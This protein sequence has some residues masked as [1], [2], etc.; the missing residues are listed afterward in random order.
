M[1]RYLVV[2]NETLGGDQLSQAIAQRL[3]A[4]PC[5]FYV[6]VPAVS[7]MRRAEVHGLASVG[8]PPWQPRDEKDAAGA[9]RRLDMELDRIGELGA[10]ARGEVGDTDPVRA[11]GA[12]LAT[13]PFFDEI[14]LSTLGPGRSRW[15]RQDLPNRVERR[16]HLPV[17]HVDGGSIGR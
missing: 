10:F 5:E 2:A 8:R 11:I 6:V 14:I 12:V 17:T 13:H 1:R 16:F 9:R 15:L 3:A 4:G 7:S